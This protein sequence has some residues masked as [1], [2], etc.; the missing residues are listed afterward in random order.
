MRRFSFLLRTIFIPV[1]T[2]LWLAACAGLSSND[3]YSYSHPVLNKKD[4]AYFI[5]IRDAIARDDRDW[6]ASQAT[7]VLCSLHGHHVVLETKK[8][9]LR[10]YDEIIN[11]YVRDAVKKQNPDDLFKNWGGIMVGRG[12]IWFDRISDGNVNEDLWPYHIITINNE[13][14]LP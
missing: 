5:A 4:K 3:P 7:L 8:Q 10:H 2:S 13:S 1:L 6:L 12:A 11:A 14:R 9:I